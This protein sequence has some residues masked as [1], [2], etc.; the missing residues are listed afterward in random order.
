MHQ[1]SAGRLRVNPGDRRSMLWVWLFACLCLVAL[2]A[3]GVA[4]DK[5]VALVIGN[6]KYGELPD[7]DGVPMRDAQAVGDA[8]KAAGFAVTVLPNL[9]RKD[10]LKAVVHFAQSDVVSA[11]L[12]LIYY[13]GHGLQIDG[14]NY[15][16]PVDVTMSSKLGIS[17]DSISE[18]E[19]IRLLEP[20]TAAG[21]AF[22]LVFDACRNLPDPSIRGFRPQDGMSKVEG[23]PPPGGF[24]VAYATQSGS[25]ASNVGPKGKNS[26]FTQAFLEQLQKDAAKEPLGTF[27]KRIKD[28]V[29][30]YPG[31]QVPSM[32][33]EIRGDV[34]LLPNAGGNALAGPTSLIGP[35]TVVDKP[36]VEWVLWPWLLATAVLMVGTLGV[37]LR[38]GGGLKAVTPNRAPIRLVDPYDG[39]I[40][41][42]LDGT[43]PLLIG[44]DA[45]ADLVFPGPNIS[46]RHAH[47]GVDAQGRAWIEDLSPVTGNGLW[48]GP[49]R[50]LPKATRVTLQRGQDIYLADKQTVIRVQ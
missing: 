15:M 31:E 12:G 26:P 32:H 11:E 41:A 46:L 1:I 48:Y 6:S 42:T 38:R 24:F 23:T 27:F 25:V 28:Q 18:Q 17:K 39:R 50:Q 20:S 47:M 2:P 49:D 16:L 36:K 4:R 21:T 30:E 5:R 22:V 40:L 10:L 9:N 33:D 37:L 19:L 3:T 7:L 13:A 44:R 14:Q 43:R 8:L 45:K 34:Y 29:I 35:Q